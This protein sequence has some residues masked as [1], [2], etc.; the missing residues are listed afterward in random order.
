MRFLKE[1]S[2][3]RKDLDDL[4]GKVFGELT[5]LNYDK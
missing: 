3:I 2:K 1:D 5:V 4:T